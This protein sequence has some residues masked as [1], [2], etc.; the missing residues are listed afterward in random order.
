MLTGTNMFNAPSFCSVLFTRSVINSTEIW[1]LKR[2]I[3]WDVGSIGGETNKMKNERASGR[4]S[5]RANE[6]HTVRTERNLR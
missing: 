3:K 1:A 4:A 2:R 5:E 6:T